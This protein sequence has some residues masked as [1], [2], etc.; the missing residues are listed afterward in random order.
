MNLLDN[1]SFAETWSDF[2]QHRIEIKK[3]MKPTGIK[4]L[5]KKLEK[6]GAESAI[7]ALEESIQNGWQGVF[8]KEGVTKTALCEPFEILW[9]LW[10]RKRDQDNRPMPV[11]D[12]EDLKVFEAMALECKNILEYAYVFQAYL[13]DEEEINF[14]SVW[15]LKWLKGRLPRYS[16]AIQRARAATSGAVD[17]CRIRT[18]E[19]IEAQKKPKASGPS[20]AELEAMLTC[21]ETNLDE[22]LRSVAL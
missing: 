14:R 6:V 21:D 18:A 7:A 2:L 20:E 4:M 11:R 15:A 9:G 19:W 22:V 12:V 13:E 5:L 17:M 10:C 8:P 3:P 16:A 1:P